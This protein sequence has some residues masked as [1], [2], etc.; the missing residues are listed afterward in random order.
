MVYKFVGKCPLCGSD[1]LDY[2]KSYGCSNWKKR[3]NGEGGCKLT[4][5]K[6]IYGKQ[7]TEDEAQRLLGGAILGPYKFYNKDGTEFMAK[8]HLQGSELKLIFE[9]QVS[10]SDIN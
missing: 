9:P 10:E 2:P 7:I 6:D 4:L 1:V 3:D 8:I 5:W